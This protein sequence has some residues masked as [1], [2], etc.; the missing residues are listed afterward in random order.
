LP[1][2]PR[3]RA[4]FPK[5]V[6]PKSLLSGSWLTSPRLGHL[7]LAE[8]RTPGPPDRC[9]QREDPVPAVARPAPAPICR[10]SF[11]MGC[12]SIHFP[13]GRV[14]LRGAPGIRALGSLWD[15][16]PGGKD[17][18]PECRNG[19]PPPFHRARRASILDRQAESPAGDSLIARRD[20][21]CNLQRAT[22]ALQSSCSRAAIA[23]G[24]TR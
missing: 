4:H 7:P 3:H 23:G 10:S 21:T 8:P 1:G 15:S 18:F 5:R 13:R 2:L 19:G 20:V 16:R 22:V 9:T 24:G 6:A 11:S 12:T 14:W 17:A